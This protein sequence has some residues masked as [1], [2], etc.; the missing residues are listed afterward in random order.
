MATAV[1]KVPAT[2]GTTAG[3]NSPLTSRKFTSVSFIS[4]RPNY[5]GKNC[6]IYNS[7]SSSSITSIKFPHRSLERFLSFV[8][9]GET[10]ETQTETLEKDQ[11]QESET[12]IEVLLYFH[13]IVL[14]S[15]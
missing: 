8:S 2:F 4:I 12:D 10:T 15:F 9:E 5:C 13:F 11:S 14:F 7:T 6:G 3:C 1:L